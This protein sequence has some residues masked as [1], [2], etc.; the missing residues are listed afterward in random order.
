MESSPCAHH[1]VYVPN[2]KL[3]NCTNQRST[4]TSRAALR[5]D[6]L[7]VLLRRNVLLR[8]LL[9]QYISFRTTPGAALLTCISAVRVLI[10]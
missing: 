10:A 6:V 2:I 9:L 3:V 8:K 5:L 4:P 7:A 1:A